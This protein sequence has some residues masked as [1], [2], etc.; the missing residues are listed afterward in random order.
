MKYK[1]LVGILGMD[2]H[3]VGAISIAKILRDAGFEV[4]YIG[5]F[6][7][8][9]TILKSAIAEDVDVIGLS[10]HSWEYL[11]FVPELVGLLRDEAPDIGLVVGGSVI[12]PKDA[13]GLLE[14][15]IDE[16]FGPDATK[17]TII[18]RMNSI[19]AQ[20]RQT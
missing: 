13:T 19:C 3:E 16:V 12:T 15:G 14:Q 7:T 20:Y 5:R 18:D 10:C 9:A 8:P 4:I 2:Q 11:H 17:Q 1:V 6:N